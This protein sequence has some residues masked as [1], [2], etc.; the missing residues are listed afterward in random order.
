MGIERTSR[1]GG[2]W[3]AGGMKGLSGGMGQKGLNE[4]GYGKAV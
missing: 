4:V 2:W 3:N 1:E